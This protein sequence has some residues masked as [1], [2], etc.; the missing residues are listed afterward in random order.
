M[1]QEKINRINELARKSRTPE[2]LTE[3]EKAEQAQLRQEYR[4]GIK[5]NLTGQLQNIE[6]VDKK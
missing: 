4:D 2:G 1:T 6:F 3:E 5:A